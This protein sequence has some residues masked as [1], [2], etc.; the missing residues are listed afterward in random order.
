MDTIPRITPHFVFETINPVRP[1]IRATMSVVQFPAQTRTV[2]KHRYEW[3]QARPHSKG[4]PALRTSTSMVTFPSL[5]FGYTDMTYNT[6]LPMPFGAA[7][8]LEDRRIIQ[9]GSYYVIGIDETITDHLA[10]TKFIS[11]DNSENVR[12][13]GR[14]ICYGNISPKNLD[15]MV[16]YFWNTSFTS[17]DFRFE[18]IQRPQSVVGWAQSC[19]RNYL[20]C[21]A[22]FILQSEL[23]TS[24]LSCGL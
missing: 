8:T 22:K 19:I 16:H 17:T 2:M 12:S 20:G 23:S 21:E 6:R 13:D 7:G 15:Q 3:T 11:L 24:V 1:L 14:S 9:R 4:V 5:L 10:L 18:P